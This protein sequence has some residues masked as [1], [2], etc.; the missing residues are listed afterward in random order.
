MKDSLKLMG[1]YRQYLEMTGSLIEL[2]ESHCN[3][4]ENISDKLKEKYAEFR[5]H[6]HGFIEQWNSDLH[7]LLKLDN[8]LKEIE[9]IEKKDKAK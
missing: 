2:L 4:S 7:L 6:T 8:E 3:K 1:I 9:N 5:K